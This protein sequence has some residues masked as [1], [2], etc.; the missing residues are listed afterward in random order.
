MSLLSL[1]LQVNEIINH[2]GVVRYVGVGVGL[3]ANVLIRHG[4]LYPGSF[5]F[6]DS[7][8]D[9]TKVAFTLLV[10]PSRVRIL[11]Q[12]ETNRPLRK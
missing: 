4:L 11:F 7:G 6:P 10:R 5:L 3:G 12:L 8:L 2:F 9:S 1:S